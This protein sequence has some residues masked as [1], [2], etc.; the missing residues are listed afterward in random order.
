VHVLLVKNAQ[1]LY[2]EPK[3]WLS[4]RAGKTNAIGK[5]VD[6]ADLITCV[7]LKSIAPL[8]LLRP[9]VGEATEA[10]PQSAELAVQEMDI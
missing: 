4:G 1:R 9:A 7:S 5:R 8:Q 10:T 3:L 6:L 2:L